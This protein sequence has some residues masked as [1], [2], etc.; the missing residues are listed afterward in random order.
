MEGNAHTQVHQHQ[1]AQTSGVVEL[2]WKIEEEQES[3]QLHHQQHG[4]G[5]AYGKGGKGEWGRSYYLLFTVLPVQHA[6]QMPPVERLYADGRPLL[7]PLGQ[8]HVCSWGC[9]KKEAEGACGAC[10]AGDEA[11]WGWG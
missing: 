10:G 1:P 11:D 2:R 6:R 7:Q 5:G 8:Q 9:H 4:G 3:Y